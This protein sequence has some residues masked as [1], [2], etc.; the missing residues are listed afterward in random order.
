MIRI[1]SLDDI[2]A[3]RES[4]DIECKLAQGEDGQGKLPKDFWKTYSAFANTF[5]GEVFLGLRQKG[6]DSFEIAGIP[7]PQ[8]VIDDLWNLLEDHNRQK[9]SCNLLT[10]DDVEVLEIEGV[11]IIRIHVPRAR[12]QD[13]PVHLGKNPLGGTYRRFGTGDRQCD[14]DTVRRMLAEQVNDTRDGEVPFG[15]SMEDIDAET[16]RGYRNVFS[17]LNPGHPFDVDEDIEFLRQIGAWGRNRER[18]H[19]G[20]TVAGILMFGTDVAR[21]ELPASYNYFVDYREVTEEET[22][23]RWSDRIIPDGTWAGNLYTFHRRVYLKLVAD[24]KVPFRLEG[25]FRQDETPAHKALREALTNTLIH[26]DYSGSAPVIIRKLPHGFEFRNPGLMRVPIDAAKQG[27]SSDCR[28]R[29]LQ[30]MFRFVRMGEQAG[31]G[32]PTIYHAWEEQHWRAPSLSESIEPSEQT[33]LFMPTLS[34]Y[35]EE[36]VE[37]LRERFGPAFDR[38]PTLERTILVL[39]AT[40][41][42]VSHAR[43]REIT[44]DHPH[45]LTMALQSLCRREWLVSE[46]KTRATTYHLARTVP[47]ED[48]FSD[49]STEDESEATRAVDGTLRVPELDRPLIDDPDLLSEEYLGYLTVRARFARNKKRIPPADMAVILLRL[50]S[51]AYFTLPALA[52]VVR[53]KERSLHQHYLKPMVQHGKLIEIP[54]G[55]IFSEKVYGTPRISSP[56]S[57]RE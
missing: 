7:G 30:K 19:E 47:A 32:I 37:A 35:P 16:L 44:P 27:G 17:A 52:S 41:R 4:F 43:L 12:R 18:D 26:A 50:C 38:L 57:G 54:A 29:N 6:D 46:G 20:P 8:K 13:R 31:S 53:R 15:F 28:N 2:L 36:I 40:E 24:L 45:D 10:H 51:D 9:V 55:K 42:S 34:L 11:S 21:Q 33:V 25:P 14:D 39:T 22:E 3:I 5:G 48:L 56:H 49:A 1:E 23:D